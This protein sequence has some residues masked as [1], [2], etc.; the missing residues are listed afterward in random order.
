MG[1]GA[2]VLPVHDRFIDRTATLH[3]TKSGEKRL[4]PLSPMA[5]ETLSLME[6]NAPSVLSVERQE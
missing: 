6:R 3:T 1:R 2:I 5:I 4:V